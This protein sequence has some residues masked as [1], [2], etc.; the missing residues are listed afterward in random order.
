MTPPTPR[1][2]P[3]PEPGDE[4]AE[5]F[6]DMLFVLFDGPEDG[7]F[8]GFHAPANCGAMEEKDAVASIMR[9][10]PDCD[11]RTAR[12]VWQELR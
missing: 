5:P 8:G 2:T 7:L 3:P 10:N 6:V 1:S 12:M 11:E 9:L 4:A